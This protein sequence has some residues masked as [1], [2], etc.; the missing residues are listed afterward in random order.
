MRIGFGYPTLEEL[1]AGLHALET[2]LSELAS[3]AT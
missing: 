3:L 2:C 1:K